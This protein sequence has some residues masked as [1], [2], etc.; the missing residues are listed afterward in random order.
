MLRN[1]SFI[2]KNVI[3]ALIYNRRNAT[4]S[5]LQLIRQIGKKLF[6]NM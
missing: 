2:Y 3:D 4:T 6:Q 1:L 5:K